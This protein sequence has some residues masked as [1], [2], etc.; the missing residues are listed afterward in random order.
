MC[1]KKKE[2]SIL[3]VYPAPKYLLLEYKPQS[4]TKAVRDKVEMYL[5]ELLV[6]ESSSR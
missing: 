3:D 4:W 5:L 1:E 2:I 6:L